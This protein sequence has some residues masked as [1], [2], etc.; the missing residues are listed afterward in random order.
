MFVSDDL[1]GNAD[2]L[3][4]RVHLYTVGSQKLAS[5]SAQQVTEQLTMLEH[6]MLCE[7]TPRE[8]VY[9]HKVI[10]SV[11]HTSFCASKFPAY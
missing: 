5:Y 9:K 7:V 2:D 11:Y 8:V 3:R 6:A 4:R 10:H 1:L